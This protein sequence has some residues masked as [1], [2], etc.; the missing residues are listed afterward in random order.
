M[1]L[2]QGLLPL[3]ARS[4]YCPLRIAPVIFQPAWSHD[5]HLIFLMRQHVHADAHLDCF[6]FS[7]IMRE[8]QR[9]LRRGSQ[10][11]DRKVYSEVGILRVAGKSIKYQ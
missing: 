10:A 11:A 5:I 8:V 7:V 6:C 9:S 1:Q 2:P 3:P 4:Q